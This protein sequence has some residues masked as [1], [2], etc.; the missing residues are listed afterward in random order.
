MNVTCLKDKTTM[1]C[2]NIGV[3]EDMDFIGLYYCTQCSNEITIS[4]RSV[5][6]I[7]KKGIDRL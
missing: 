5:Q 2:R 1:E 3:S 4:L 6:E 7:I